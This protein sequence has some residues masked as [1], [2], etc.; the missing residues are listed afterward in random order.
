MRATTLLSFQSAQRDRLRN[1]QHRLQI[2]RQVPAR[3]EESRTLDSQPCGALIQSLKL[4]E[5]LLQ[6]VLISKNTDVVLHRFFQVAMNLI[7]RVTFSALKWRKH[8][9]R[10]LVDLLCIN[11]YRPGMLCVFSRR[12]PSPPAEDKK[13]RKGIA[14]QSICAMESGC[15]FT[16][17]E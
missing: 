1:R 9:I 16:G 11:C 10:C 4:R 15:C 13:I 14:T 3:I 17:R 5:P 6:V 8:F 7:R 2:A 12:Q